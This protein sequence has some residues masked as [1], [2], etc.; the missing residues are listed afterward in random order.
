MKIEKL[1]R[2]A[3]HVKNLEKAEALFSD[4]FGIE[5]KRA[6]IPKAKVYP[7]EYGESVH[8]ESETCYTGVSL[9]SAGLELIETDPPCEEEGVRSFHFKVSDLEEA[10]AEMEAKGMRLVSEIVFGG[11]KEAVYSPE[12]MHGARILLVEYDAPDSISAILEG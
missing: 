4:L 3:L 11:L 6:P 8:R 12:D 9:S 1:D 2:V 10:K 5:F 7:T